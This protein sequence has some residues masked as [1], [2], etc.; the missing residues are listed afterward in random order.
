MLGQEYSL[1]GR[2]AEE[3]RSFRQKGLNKEQATNL[4]AHL[5]G[6]P[7]SRRTDAVGTTRELVQWSDKQINRLL[8]LKHRVEQGF[9]A[10]D[11]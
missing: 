7:V 1:S 4:V 2:P 9:G 10:D 5:H 11:R 3:I 8:E 6:I